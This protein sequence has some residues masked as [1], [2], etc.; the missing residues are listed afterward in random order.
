MR[1]DR[2]RQAISILSQ[3]P[4]ERS[5]ARSGDSAVGSLKNTLVVLIAVV[6]GL[7]C[8][9]FA[10]EGLILSVGYI[11]CI[12]LCVKPLV[13]NKSTDLLGSGKPALNRI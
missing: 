1:N 12:A 10:A 7:G 4:H 3:E 9:Y 11:L 13:R 6:L 5:I 2:H 8:L